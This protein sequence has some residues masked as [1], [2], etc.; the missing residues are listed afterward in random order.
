MYPAYFIQ[1]L[2]KQKHAKISC[3]QWNEKKKPTKNAQTSGSKE[4]KYA[5]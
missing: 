1:Q 2:Y 4:V 3:I 5:V